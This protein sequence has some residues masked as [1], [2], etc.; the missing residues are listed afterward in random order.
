MD[1]PSKN[2]EMLQRLANGSLDAE[3]LLTCLA[4]LGESSGTDRAELAEALR[5]RAR[6]STEAWD[7]LANWLSEWPPP[8]SDPAQV[9]QWLSDFEAVALAHHGL[10]ALS[11][12]TEIPG[13]AIAA[14]MEA[15]LYAHNALSER[16][17]HARFA[18]VAERQIA[19]RGRSFPPWTWLRP[20][21]VRQWLTQGS[22]AARAASELWI[23]GSLHSEDA[24]ILREEISSNDVLR[25]AYF[26]AL[27][28][29]LRE[30][31]VTRWTPA[32]SLDVATSEDDLTFVPPVLDVPLPHKDTAVVVR[33]H[34]SGV[35]WRGPDGVGQLLGAGTES[36]RYDVP[37]LGELETRLVF[38][39]PTLEQD[40]WHG[41][42]SLRRIAS[43][44]FAELAH[45][46]GRL[47]QRTA[48]AVEAFIAALAGNGALAQAL[49]TAHDAFES[50]VDTSEELQDRVR[51]ALEARLTLSLALK[52]LS[53]LRGPVVDL[54]GRL[55]AA[56][57]A[58]FGSASA[59][60][61]I[62]DEDYA[63]LTEGIPL[64]TAAWWGA[65]ERLDRRVPRGVV[66]AALISG[67][68]KTAA[69]R[70]GA[71]RAFGGR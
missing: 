12:T 38:H 65:R 56:D 19:E 60:Q 17:D 20:G 69:G 37:G 58:L 14:L 46:S 10:S 9:Y 47:V 50:G 23:D 35:W 31:H 39:A 1:A 64:D 2:R 24:A 6:D 53:A 51:Y 28:E 71:L 70:H 3:L 44:E 66:E 57:E 32:W 21:E 30:L 26:A 18:G 36:H 63:N 59:L 13:P 55:F 8:P 34:E 4:A 43:D 29:R 49:R 11:D 41:L 5:G 40:V 52:T 27:R 68:M 67:E 48:Q 33:G 42:A 22:E 15:V 54:N 45:E 61:V 25:E 62:H 16:S 7:D